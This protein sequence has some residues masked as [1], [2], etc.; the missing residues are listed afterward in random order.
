MFIE[1]VIISGTCYIIVDGKFITVDCKKSVETQ[2]N[3]KHNLF[4]YSFF[5][6]LLLR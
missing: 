1:H 4:H 6:L 5:F 3:G 2:S